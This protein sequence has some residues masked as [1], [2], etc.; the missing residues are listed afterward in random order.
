MH[1]HGGGCSRTVDELQVRG[2]HKPVV[3][4]K[5][6]VSMDDERQGCGSD[7]MDIVQTLVSSANRQILKE[8]FSDAIP[9]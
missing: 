7:V 2:F 8:K 9:I 6:V 4:R 3:P 5:Q 1:G